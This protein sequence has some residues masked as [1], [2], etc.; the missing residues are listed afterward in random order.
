MDAAMFAKTL[1]VGVWALLWT[2]LLSAQAPTTPQGDS[3]GRNGAIL[4]TGTIKAGD[5][6][7]CMSVSRAQAMSRVLIEVYQFKPRYRQP[8]P[9]D[10]TIVQFSATDGPPCATLSAPLVEGFTV[11]ASILSDDLQKT[12]LTDSRVVAPATAG[13]PDGTHAAALYAI[14]APTLKSVQEGADIVSG[15]F[16]EGTQL[17]VDS[18]PPANNAGTGTATTTATE[19]TDS[20]C[21]SKVVVLVYGH[22]VSKDNLPTPLT[23]GA[24]KDEDA[25]EQQF[26]G[27]YAISMSDDTAFSAPLKDL[28]LLA[29]QTVRA[30][31]VDRSGKQVSG[32]SALMV[33]SLTDWGRVRAYLSGGGTLSFRDGFSS[34]LPMARFVTDVNW[35]QY[36]DFDAAQATP[37]NGPQAPQRDGHRHKHVSIWRPRQVNTFFDVELTQA[38][39]TPQP[40]TTTPGSADPAKPA[41]TD[42]ASNGGTGTT[43][44]DL[45]GFVNAPKTA[46]LQ[47]GIY[48]PF[49]GDRQTWTFHGDRNAVFWAPSLRL[50][51]LTADVTT[52]AVG[53]QTSSSD[54]SISTA[55]VTKTEVFKLYSAGMII[56]HQKLSDTPDRAPE[57]ISYVHLSIGRWGNL[58]ETALAGSPDKLPWRW[59]MEGRLKIPASVFEIGF[60]SNA[61]IGNSPLPND[62]RFTFGA[63][64]E[65]G[66]VVGKLSA[67]GLH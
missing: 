38:S 55:E 51:L 13:S 18:A 8:E 47:M 21:I 27:R 15:Q 31:G 43:G 25:E 2:G 44:T 29:G 57:I 41:S 11:V 4:L 46:T 58:R 34:V 61:A 52:P 22:T 1:S 62:L 35:W 48:M 30:F 40:T 66:D 59:G 7:V 39:A 60:E 5:R 50:G 67:L 17:C 10:R 6:L 19:P 49:Y 23:K 37:A 26:L 16:A 20:P 42:V 65:I 12:G 32:S 36:N 64:L 3:A 24:A 28:R 56:G 53:G 14:D 45:N 9:L 33:Q 54:P 63:R